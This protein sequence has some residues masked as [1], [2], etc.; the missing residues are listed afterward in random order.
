VDVAGGDQRIILSGY[1]GNRFIVTGGGLLG[2][3]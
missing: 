1:Y 2:T 3:Q